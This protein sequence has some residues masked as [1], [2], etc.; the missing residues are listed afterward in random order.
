MRRRRRFAIVL[1]TLP[2][3]TAT[4]LAAGPPITIAAQVVQ[5]TN[6]GARMVRLTGQVANGNAGERVDVLVKDCRS[7]FFRVVG[8]AQTTTGGAY[9]AR[10]Y[11]DVRGTF[12]SRWRGKRSAG[13]TAVPMLIVGAVQTPGTRIWKTVVGAWGTG[14]SFAGREVV[15]QRLADSGWVPVRR[16]RL[17]REEFGNF[18]TIFKIPTRGL[19]MR[20]LA[21]TKTARPCFRAGVSEVF[22][23]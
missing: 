9:E 4:G 6:T 2:A 5:N 20:I 21:P 1:L 18:S 22:Q 15:L 17:R 8:G 3:A 16:A 13:V 14:E 10:V 19:T 12:V 23:S 7:R 11:L